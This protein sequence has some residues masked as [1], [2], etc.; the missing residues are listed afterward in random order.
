MFRSVLSRTIATALLIA[1]S[2]VASA[3]SGGSDAAPSRIASGNL[4]LALT[5]N[6]NSHTYRL[7]NVSLY[8]Y[9]NTTSTFLTTSNDPSETSLSATLPTGSYNANLYGWTLERDLGD[10]QFAALP[11][12]LVSNPYVGFGI[13]NGT[14]TT[15]SFQFQTDGIVVTVGA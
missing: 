10:G 14:T 7:T 11:A 9:G 12:T 6:A 15:I 1:G 2:L 4:S 8:I 3:C 5:A 13:S